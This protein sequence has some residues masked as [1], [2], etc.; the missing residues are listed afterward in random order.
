MGVLFGAL[1]SCRARDASVSE[2]HRPSDSVPFLA[3][4]DTA[5][6]NLVAQHLHPD[7]SR[8]VAEYLRRD[9]AGDFT[10]TNSWEASAFTCPGRMPGWDGVTVITGYRVEPL[11]VGQDTAKYR[12]HYQVFG[13]LGDDSAGQGL[14]VRPRT[15]VDTFV[16]LRTVFGWRIDLPIIDP[17]LLPRAALGFALKG[18]DRQVLDSLASAR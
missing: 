6:C 15:E 12:V 3:A 10:S 17:H 4:D 14:T 11:A 16:V 7:P 18:R 9:V 5:G 13:P 8:L 1:A 2:G